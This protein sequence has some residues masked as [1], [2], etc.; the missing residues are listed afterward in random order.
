MPSRGKTARRGQRHSKAGKQLRPQATIAP[1][2]DLSYHG[3]LEQPQRYAPQYEHSKG[4]VPNPNTRVLLHDHFQ[5]LDRN[6]DGTIDPFERA[7][8]RLDMDHDLA[9]RQRQ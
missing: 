2:P 3:I 6:R 8:G 4:G 7:L 1:K 5:E 9:D